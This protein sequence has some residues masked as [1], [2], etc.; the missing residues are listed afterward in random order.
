MNTDMIAYYRER[1][2]EYEKLYYKP[3]R[4][5]VLKQ[6][7]NIL[8]EIFNGMSLLE[9][10]CGTGFWTDKVAAT[11]KS[12]TATDINEAVLNIAQTKTYKPATV[13]FECRDMYSVDGIAYDGL[14]GGFIWSHIRLE[15]VSAFVSTM[16]KHVEK[17]GTIVFMD[18]I[19]VEG[20]NS[21]ITRTDARGNTYQ[22]RTL[23]NGAQY[24]VLKNFPTKEYL[25]NLIKGEADEI[26]YYN[27]EYYWI[28]EY[29]TRA[30]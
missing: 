30:K 12:I 6:A 8:Q 24:E 9:I 21:P 22:T 10:A 18:N 1:A 29:K 3:E 17:G 25:I 4:Q 20:S 28:L 15:E 13:N 26:K 5:E 14:F 19:Y 11:A 23:E 16:N 7:A 27:L 2:K